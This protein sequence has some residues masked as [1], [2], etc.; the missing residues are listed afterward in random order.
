M[1]QIILKQV[2]YFIFVYGGTQNF[3]A[4]PQGKFNLLLSFYQINHIFV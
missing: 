4:H 1:Q 3:Y 2:L